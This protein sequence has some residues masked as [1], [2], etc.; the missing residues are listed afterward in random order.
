MLKKKTME[1]K[2]NREEDF[3]VVINSEVFDKDFDNV[4][5]EPVEEDDNY[6]GT[7]EY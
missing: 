7:Y 5:W 4:G 3:G 6:K 2:N 1:N